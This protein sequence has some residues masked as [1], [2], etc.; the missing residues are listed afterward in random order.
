MTCAFH[1]AP[2]LTTQKTT[3]TTMSVWTEHVAKWQN[4]TRCALARQRGLICLARGDV[5]CDVLFVGEA[6]G[7]S[8]NALGVPFVGPAG[9]LLDRV[10]EQALGGFALCSTCGRMRYQSA[11]DWTCKA[12][13]ARANG[14]GGRSITTAYTN[15][16]ACF[17]A[18]A[19]GR[20]DNEPE[21]EEVLACRKR[22]DEFV[23]LARPELVVF[24]GNM[25]EQWC[26]VP[27]SAASVKIVHPA[28]VLRQP[29]VQKNLAVQRAVVTLRNAVV[30]TFG[31]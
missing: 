20:G 5:P 29:L 26:N 15:L 31:E 6:P 1:C 30:D 19:K 14:Y 13:H 10:I 11:G 17:P 25:A 27:H 2:F 24:V 22:L 8:E 23:E 12:G 18:E 9:Q 7:A 21:V 16:V 4:C 28:S 3:E